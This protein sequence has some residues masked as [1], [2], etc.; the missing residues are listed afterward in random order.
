[1]SSLSTD[2]FVRYYQAYNS[3]DPAALTLFYSPDVIFTTAQGEQRG[4]EAILN[5]YGYLIGQFEDRMTPDSIL[6]DG[7]RAAVEITDVFTA[8][9]DVADFMGM[10][11]KK[12]E[13]LTLKLCALYTVSNNKITHATIYTR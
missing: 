13:S 4:V 12:G 9:Q 6:V 1:M 11:L 10:S 5:T 7:N 3:E 8:R 2:F